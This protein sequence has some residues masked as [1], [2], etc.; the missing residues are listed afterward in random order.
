MPRIINLTIDA[1]QHGKRFDQ[2]MAVLL[3]ELSR[4]RIQRWIKNGALT[5]NDNHVSAKQK[6]TIGDSIR[7]TIIDISEASDSAEDMALAIVHEDDSIIVI[8][9]PAGLVV[10]PGAGN[11]QGTLLNALLFHYPELQHIP[12]AGIVHRLDK[13]TSGLLVV[14]KTLE[15]QFGLVQQLQARTVKRHYMALVI[16]ELL[17]GGKIEAS[18]GR[19][20]NDRLRMAVVQGGKQALTHYSIVRRYRG[21]T[22][23]ECRLAT[24]R[25]HQI[26]VH[27]A[28]IRH[29]LVGD[30]LYGG[31]NRLP[32]GLTA[33]T[34]ELVLHFPRQALHA[35]TLAFQHPKRHELLQFTSELPVD[36]TTLLAA[37]DKQA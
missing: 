24:G 2:A 6:V 27:M 8:D 36:M 1:A 23:L 9:K 28:S 34:R 3:P 22:L 16:G 33:E 14:A 26:R 30:S 10:H 15:A 21:L 37:L 13:D 25:T 20:R 35:K 7:G 5:L 12:R 4:S 17:G 18:I 11:H 19:C 32:K 29:T 31:R